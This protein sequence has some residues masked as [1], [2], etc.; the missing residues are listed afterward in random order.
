MLAD[1]GEPLFYATWENAVFIHY[2]SEPA[3][4]QKCVPFTLDLFEG[5]AFVSVVAFTLCQMR[6]RRGGRIGEWLFKPIATHPFFNLRT[7]VRHDGERGIYFM[8]E[9]LSNRLSVALG[10]I[11]F[12]LPYHYGRLHYQNDA[13]NG[14]AQGRVETGES[15]FAY[16]ATVP[17][18]Q[19]DECEPESLTEFLLERYT[20]FTGAGRRRK[21]FRVW[22]EPWQQVATETEVIERG[23]LATTGDW[24][25]TACLHSGNYSPGVNVWM[26]WPHSVASASC[27]WGHGLEAHA[28]SKNYENEIVEN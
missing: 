1:R 16:Q 6:P 4:L 18:E 22:H 21:F 17:R 15:S 7:Y 28:T 5:R 24:W 8:A 11:S 10:P 25:Q 2:E 26:G 19:L 12:G 9:W 20:A 14:A 23:L 27:R 13:K 3:A